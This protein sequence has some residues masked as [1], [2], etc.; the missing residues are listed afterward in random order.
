MAL[1]ELHR[2]KELLLAER[3]DQEMGGAGGVEFLKR[4]AVV[5]RQ[6]DEQSRRIGLGRVAEGSDPF[7]PLGQRAARVDHGDRCP[8]GDEAALGILG[9]PG[10]DRLPAGA[11][12]RR[13]QL[14]AMA[15]RQYEQRRR[16]AGGGHGPGSSLAGRLEPHRSTLPPSPQQSV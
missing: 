9:A 1:G 14:V 12:D 13:G 15:E 11:L 2:L 5:A 6:Q 7:P 3:A 16:T 8:R 4:V 10:G